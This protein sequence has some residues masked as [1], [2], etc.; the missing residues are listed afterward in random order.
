MITRI[1]KFV[2]SSLFTVLLLS[3]CKEKLDLDI[4]DESP[5]LVVEGEVTTETDSS[6][7]RLTLSSNYYAAV[8]LPVVNNAAVSVN[9][10]AFSFNATKGAYVP[11][12]GYV[13]KRD[14]SYALQIDYNGATYKAETKIEPL[15]RIDSLFQTWKKAEGFLKEGYSISYAAFDERPPIK[16]TFFKSGYFDTIT[17]RDSFSRARTLFDNS[18]TPVAVPYVFEIPFTRFNSG[19]VYIAIFRSIDR[20]MF[21]FIQTLNQQ[22]S[23]APG[24]FQVPPA[25]LPTN[26]SNGGLGYFAGYDVKRFRY[27]VK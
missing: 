9:G 4:P 13:G 22:N 17:Q 21:D 15:F 12:A 18:L 19:D 8:S 5:R 6:F 26:I 3:S 27:T 7:V 20:A 10:V 16:Y 24:P 23:G 11:P 25:N 14:S 2:L 1:S